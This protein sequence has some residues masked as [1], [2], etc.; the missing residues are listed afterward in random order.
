MRNIV[1]IRNWL[2][3]VQV[4]PKSPDTRTKSEFLPALECRN[5]NKVKR[6]RGGVPCVPD[7]ASD[8]I[9]T[10]KDGEHCRAAAIAAQSHVRVGRGAV[11]SD[12]Y[13]DLHVR[14]ETF[15]Q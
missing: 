14:H 4:D 9:V 11:G 5:S 7:S 13:N 10:I 15:Q 2:K 12:E 8:T 1:K 6:R 3:S